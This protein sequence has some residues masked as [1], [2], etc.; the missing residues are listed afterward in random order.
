MKHQFGAAERAGA[1]PLLAAKDHGAP[2]VFRPE[3]LLREARRQKNLPM[4][5]VPPVCLLDPDGDIVQ[6]VRTFARASPSRTAL[7]HTAEPLS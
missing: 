5:A 6:D 7:L 4:E 3:A 2:S 1:S